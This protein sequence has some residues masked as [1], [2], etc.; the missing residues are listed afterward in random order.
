MVAYCV[1]TE[2]SQAPMKRYAQQRNVPEREGS[3]Q[4][5]AR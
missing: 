3:R 4:T 5:L 1:A 2:V